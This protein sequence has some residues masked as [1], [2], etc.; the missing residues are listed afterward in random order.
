M[1]IVFYEKKFLMNENTFEIVDE[2]MNEVIVVVLL[3]WGNSS[4]DFIPCTDSS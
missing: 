3:H 4:R 2:A 1:L